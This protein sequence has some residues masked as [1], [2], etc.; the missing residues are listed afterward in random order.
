MHDI[1]VI[2]LQLSYYYYYLFTTRMHLEVG[3]DY[4]FDPPC[5]C[6]CF[7]EDIM[8]GNVSNSKA[9]VN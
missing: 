4:L 3:A 7:G 1:F 9:Q 8:M 6:S 5:H 2:M